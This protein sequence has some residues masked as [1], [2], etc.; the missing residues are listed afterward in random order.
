MHEGRRRLADV[1]NPHRIIQIPFFQRSYVWE[2]EQWERFLYDIHDLINNDIPNYFMGPI[3]L[4]EQTNPKNKEYGE[5]R[6]LIDGQQRL[7]SIFLL[8]KC[9]ANKLEK[10]GESLNN[11]LRC[12]I[13]N[14]KII[15]EHNHNDRKIFEAILNGELNK[16]IEEE[17]VNNKVLKCYKY[18]EKNI[19]PE[20]NVKDWHSLLSKIYFIG[21][22]LDEKEDE[23]QVFD[24]LNSIGVS[25][26]TAELL[27]NLLFDSD[28]DNWILYQDTWKK[29]FE[30]E[31]KK[32]WDADIGTGNNKRKNIDFFLQ[33]FLLLK[34]HTDDK[35]INVGN[36][37][38][39]VGDPVVKSKPTTKDKPKPITIDKLY[40]RYKSYIRAN[41]INYGDAKFINDIIE[42]SKIYKKNINYE[43]LEVHVNLYPYSFSDKINLIAFGIPVTPI[44]PYLLFILTDVKDKNEQDAMFDLLINYFIRRVVCRRSTK[45]YGL[46]FNNFISRRVR[47]LKELKKQFINISETEEFPD[48]KQFEKGFMESILI[49]SYAKSI[50]YLLELSMRNAKTSTALLPFKSYEIEHIMPKKWEEHWP[51]NGIDERV[52]NE[53]KLTMGNL[54]IV[55]PKLNKSF[56]NLSWK[57]KRAEL[58]EYTK[59]IKTFDDDRFLGSDTWDEDKIKERGEFLYKQAVKVWPALI[60]K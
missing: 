52:R 13:T 8:Y 57:E 14:N 49:S 12:G 7:T 3:I 42:K 47:T 35:N 29:Y 17:Y 22:D 37:D 45:H 23:Q 9:A 53:K 55:S 41:N 31:E 21:I 16:V 58:L 6:S 50:L 59:G 33:S 4:K 20:L 34:S 24:T 51:L 27:K 60:K 25:L 19:E 44:I 26:T 46:V 28:E 54:T 10:K 30:N 40:D 43:K 11:I 1:L 32:F 39:N 48:N 15:L 2:E 5:V 36:K 18:F 38:I 56:S